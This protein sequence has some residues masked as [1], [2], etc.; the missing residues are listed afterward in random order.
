MSH[1]AI[2]KYRKI[3][4]SNLGADPPT[5]KENKHS[6]I[7]GKSSNL[8]NFPCQECKQKKNRLTPIKLG[9]KNQGKKLVAQQEGFG[10]EVPIDP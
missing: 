2:L 9:S 10:Q 7:Q 1:V 4:S 6:R 5:I 3:Y 8:Q